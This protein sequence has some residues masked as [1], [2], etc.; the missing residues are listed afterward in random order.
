MPTLVAVT[1]EL[2]LTCGGLLAPSARPL[3]MGVGVGALM[4]AVLL[5]AATVCWCAQD[6][7]RRPAVL[8]VLLAAQLAV[9]TGTSRAHQ[10]WLLGCSEPDS[11]IVV[12]LVVVWALAGKW[13]PWLSCMLRWQ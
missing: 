9:W 2:A 8:A 13:Q 10:A 4:A 5:A 3:V 12:V 1:S 7:P 11:G 6:P